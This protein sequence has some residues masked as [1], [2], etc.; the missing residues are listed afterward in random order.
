MKPLKPRMGKRGTLT[1]AGVIWMSSTILSCPML[2]F[3][4]TAEISS[5]DGIRTVC[6]TEWPDGTTNHSH[7]EH[8]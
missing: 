7:Q 4:T 6:Y 2:L 1:I 3:F 8:M 5:K